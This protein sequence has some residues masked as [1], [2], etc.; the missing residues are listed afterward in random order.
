[1]ISFY[2]TVRGDSGEKMLYLMPNSS[3]IE[4][5]H[6][7]NLNFSDLEKLTNHLVSRFSK[8]SGI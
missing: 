2:P 3:Q 5:N 8:G 7:L 6:N 1:M 4:K